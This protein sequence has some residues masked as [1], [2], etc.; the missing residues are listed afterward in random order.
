[1]N[2]HERRKAA[3]QERQQDTMGRS[4][5]L[6]G[7]PESVR[8]HPM[9]QEGQ[10]RAAAGEGPPQGYIDAIHDAA[11]LV[12]R[13]I[14]ARPSPPDLKWLEWDAGSTFIAAGLDVG[15]SYLADSPDAFALLEWLDSATGRKLSLNMAG[16]ALRIAGQIPER[17]EKESDGRTQ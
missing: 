14:A 5:Q 4:F 11:A 7:L 13:W 12:P 8:A 3:S 2:R 6:G 15:A 17:A 16:W 10:R 9:F 1:M